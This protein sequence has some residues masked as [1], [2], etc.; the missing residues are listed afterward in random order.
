[1]K[2]GIVVVYLSY[3]LDNV[4]LLV[5][6]TTRTMYV[7]ELT[8]RV[9]VVT[10]RMI[11][12]DHQPYYLTWYFTMCPNVWTYQRSYVLTTGYQ[13]FQALSQSVRRA[14]DLSVF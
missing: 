11:R 1:M 3:Q 2:S 10:R 13:W 5:D 4:I 12:Y 7:A 8:R 9:T 14:K 6:S